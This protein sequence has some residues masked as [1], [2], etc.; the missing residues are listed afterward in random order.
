VQ[1]ASS[2]F[3]DSIFLACQGVFNLESGYAPLSKEE[4]KDALH[5]VLECQE[6]LTGLLKKFA[7]ELVG[8]SND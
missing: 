6:T 3:S 8:A 7:D 5:M 1:A 2:K 4:M